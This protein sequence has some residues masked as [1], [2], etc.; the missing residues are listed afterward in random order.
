MSESTRQNLINHLKAKKELIP[1]WANSIYGRG[2]YIV[3]SNGF[4]GNESRSAHIDHVEGMSWDPAGTV[5]LVSEG[6]LVKGEEKNAHK[7]SVTITIAG[8]SNSGKTLIQHIIAEALRDKGFELNFTPRA[9]KEMANAIKDID[10][11]SA[12]VRKQTK[13]LLD[14]QHLYKRVTLGGK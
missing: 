1:I 7:D 3:A 4:P 5:L 10:K 12:T 14:E 9:E 6:K 13:I 11:A 2:E 8:M